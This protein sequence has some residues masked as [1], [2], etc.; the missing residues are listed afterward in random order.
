MVMNVYHFQ[1]ECGW[2]GQWMTGGFRR[3]ISLLESAEIQLI[4]A[5]NTIAKSVWR[6]VYGQ[7]IKGQLVE[8]N[9]TAKVGMAVCFACKKSEEQFALYDSNNGEILHPLLCNHCGNKTVIFHTA[10]SIAC[11][12]CQAIVKA[13]PQL[14]LQELLQKKLR[15]Y[16]ISMPSVV[17]DTAVIAVGRGSAAF[18]E[19]IQE[20]IIYPLFTMVKEENHPQGDD[21]FK[22]LEGVK[23]AILPANLEDDMEADLVKRLIEQ[24]CLLDIEVVPIMITPPIFEG[25]RRMNRVMEHVK[26]IQKLAKQTILLSGAAIEK[27]FGPSIELYK[28]HIPTSIKDLLSNFSMQNNLFS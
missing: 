10:E 16:K 23:K 7:I 5:E 1:C 8:E 3:K 14:P 9:V 12:C 19:L 27:E 26:E 4:G 17:S 28:K 6:R 24:F 20:D 11:P 18:M 2:S 15:Q 13:G 21:F 25:S 22:K